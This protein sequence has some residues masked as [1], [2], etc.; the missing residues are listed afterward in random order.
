[1]KT[2][3]FL[4]LIASSGSGGGFS[5]D[6]KSSSAGAAAPTLAPL[7]CTGTCDMQFVADD[8]TSGTW[9]SRDS[10]TWAATKVGSPTKQATS[11]FSGRSELT[12]FALGN[13]FSLAANNAHNLS[14]NR[15]YEVI[16]KVAASLSGN[17]NIPFAFGTGYGASGA[18]T[19]WAPSAADGKLYGIGFDTSGGDHQAGGVLLSTYFSKYVLFTLVIESGSSKLVLYANGAAIGSAAT[20]GTYAGAQ[21]APGCFGVS[22]CPADPSNPYNGSI[23]EFARHLTAFS[24]ATVASRAVDF[25]ALKGY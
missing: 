25:N 23:V 16:V 6:G 2:L 5:G 18:S 13:Y 21:T 14:A 3:F 10:N 7:P 9:T 17:Y 24:A 4:A 1:M 8:W 22:W 20:M 11:Q 19:L 15:T 12:G